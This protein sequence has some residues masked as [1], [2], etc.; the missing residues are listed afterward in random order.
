M[1]QAVKPATGAPEGLFDVMLLAGNHLYDF[2]ENGVRDTLRWLGRS[3]YPTYRGGMNLAKQKNCYFRKRR[4][5]IRVSQ[6]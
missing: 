4:R 6:F 3:R 5:P 1:D 2:G